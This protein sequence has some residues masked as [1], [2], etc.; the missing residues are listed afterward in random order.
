MRKAAHFIVLG[1]RRSGVVVTNQGR[2]E[3]KALEEE[4]A[5]DERH[6]N[7]PLMASSHLKASCQARV[8]VFWAL[9]RVRVV[10]AWRP[11]LA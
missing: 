5:H 7:A 8:G 9:M 1:A 2:L 4:A 11:R 3:V 10:R 6:P